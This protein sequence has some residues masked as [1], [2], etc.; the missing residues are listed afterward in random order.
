MNKLI[1][2]DFK[3]LSGLNEV[4]VEEQIQT[5]DRIIRLVKSI[6]GTLF[7]KN[8][9]DSFI[10]VGDEYLLSIKNVDNEVD[11]FL[12]NDD[13]YKL[14]DKDGYVP[15]ENVGTV[16]DLEVSLMSLFGLDKS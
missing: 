13:M 2:E 15:F 16:D 11:V 12:D 14:F 10:D 8:N 7:L 3:K 4:V 5:D 1:L 6:N 9:V